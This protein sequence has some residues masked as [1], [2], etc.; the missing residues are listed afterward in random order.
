MSWKKVMFTHLLSQIL[1]SIIFEAI[2]SRKQS[3]TRREILQQI[4]SFLVMRIQGMI[5][6]K[7]FE[8]LTET[9]IFILRL[10]LIITTLIETRIL[11]TLTTIINDLGNTTRTNLEENTGL[12]L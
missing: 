2:Y 12:Q 10:F 1:I 3:M 11:R 7:A 9:K 8:I 5:L 4:D 6:R